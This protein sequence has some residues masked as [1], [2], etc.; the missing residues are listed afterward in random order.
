MLSVKKKRKLGDKIRQE[1]SFRLLLE[2]SLP[3]RSR[4]DQL[5]QTWRDKLQH[6]QGAP[7]LRMTRITRM[8]IRKCLFE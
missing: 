3:I 4:R 7:P 1:D 5:Q 2:K 8:K 6:E